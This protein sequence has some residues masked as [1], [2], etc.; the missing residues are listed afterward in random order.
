MFVYY[1]Y[2]YSPVTYGEEYKYP[3]WAE[4]MGL[5]IAA[6]SM[7][8]VPIYAIY[9]TVRG[10]SS[11]REGTLREVSLLFNIV[12]SVESYD[13][14]EQYIFIPCSS[15]VSYNRCGSKFMSAIVKR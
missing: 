12:D 4:I 6:S 11:D 15:N 2:Q 1:L 3:K 13:L 10:I 9:Y 8:W 7:I 5:L 14:L